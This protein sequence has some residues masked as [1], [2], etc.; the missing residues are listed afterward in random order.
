MSRSPFTLWDTPQATIGFFTP[1]VAGPVTLKDR[2]PGGCQARS[3]AEACRRKARRAKN[4]F[5]TEGADRVQ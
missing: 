4:R 5:A 3:G 2:E 1:I